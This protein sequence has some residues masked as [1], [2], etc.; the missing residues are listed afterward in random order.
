[1]FCQLADAIPFTTLLMPLKHC[2]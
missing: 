1:L 2:Y